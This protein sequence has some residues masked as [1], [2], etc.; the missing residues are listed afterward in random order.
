VKLSHDPGSPADRLVSL[1]QFRGYTVAGMFLVNF[2]G[3]FRSVHPLLDHHNTYCSYADTIMP[4]FFFAVGFAYRLTFLRARARDGLARAC[5]HAVVRNLLLLAIGVAIYGFG[6]GAKTWEEVRALGLGGYLLQTCGGSLFQTLV[7]I[8]V[9][10]LWVLPVMGAGGRTIA[11]F[12]AASGLLHLGLSGTFWYEWV[13]THRAIDGGLLGFLTWTVPTLVGALAHDAV[14][15]RPG[16]SVASGGTAAAGVAAGT[17]AATGAGGAQDAG[18][19]SGGANSAGAPAARGPVAAL[20]PLL[21]WG[22]ALMVA[23]YALSCGNAVAHGGWFTE[24]PFVPPSRPVDLWTMSQKT[25]SLSYLTFGAGFSLAVY[26]VCVLAC[27]LRGLQWGVFRTLGQNALLA[28][29]IHSPI[30]AGVQAVV[31]RDAPL[32][33]AMAGFVVFFAITWAV[34]RVLERSRIYLRL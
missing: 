12:A 9:T 11:L 5:R 10:G 31:P 25:G 17:E 19:A 3:D 30:S 23:G 27:D 33:A 7:H 28:Y 13:T 20:L 34:M 26:A 4:Q 6:S 2:L 1:D 14:A 15:S 16:R 21:V 8:G 18:P 29:L 24:P 22:A 32:W